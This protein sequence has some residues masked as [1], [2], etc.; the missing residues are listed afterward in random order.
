[1]FYVESIM[2]TNDYNVI[3]CGCSSRTRQ[4]CASHNSK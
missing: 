1:L 2:C 4:A 3:V